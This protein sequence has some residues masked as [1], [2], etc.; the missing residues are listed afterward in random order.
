MDLTAQKVIT[1]HVSWSVA[2]G[3][4]PVPILDFGLVTAL[5]LEMIKSLCEVYGIPFNQSLAKTRVIAV[6]GGMTPRVMSSIIKVIP[7]IGSVTG[8]ISMPLLS[9]A[10]TYAVGQ[11]LAKHFQ[12]G[13]TLE[14]FEMSKFNDLFI[15]MKTEGKELAQSFADQFKNLADAG[16]FRD[17]EKLKQQGVITPEEYERI[18]KRMFDRVKITL[19]ID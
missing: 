6:I 9:G 10:S 14:N 16:S 19:K 12:E 5:Q 4:L 7:I 2:A 18:K 15:Q 11:V 13:G 1:N 8:A 3:L 17:I